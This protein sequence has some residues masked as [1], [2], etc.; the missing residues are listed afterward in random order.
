MTTKLKHRWH[1]KD[2]RRKSLFQKIILFLTVIE[3]ISPFEMCAMCWVPSVQ[4]LTMPP[5]LLSSSKHL[6]FGT[7]SSVISSSASLQPFVINLSVFGEL[8]NM[9]ILHNRDETVCDH[10]CLFSFIYLNVFIVYLYCSMYQF[11]F[12]FNGWTILHFMD[13][14]QFALSTY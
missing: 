5:P 4:W 11:F 8:L 2:L 12:L 1:P 13:I 14:A 6:S 7:A 10:L 3:I 9:N